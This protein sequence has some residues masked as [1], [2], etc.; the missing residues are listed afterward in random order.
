VETALQ[1]AGNA[2]YRE[3]VEILLQSNGE[4]ALSEPR[5]SGGLLYIFIFSH[6]GEK[7]INQRFPDCEARTLGGGG[8]VVCVRDILILN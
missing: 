6:K 5:F 7:N 2:L 8:Q 3:T 4:L 1:R